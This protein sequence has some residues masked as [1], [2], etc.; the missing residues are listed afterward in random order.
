MIDLQLPR[1]LMT[2]SLWPRGEGVGSIF[3]LA[4]GGPFSAL[5]TRSFAVPEHFWLREA[6]PSLES[7]IRAAFSNRGDVEIVT[8]TPLEKAERTEW[9]KA[10]A[11]R[12][13]V[14]PALR[15]PSLADWSREIFPLS[16]SEAGEVHWLRELR[17]YEL[18]LGSVT[19]SL[20]ALRFWPAFLRTRKV[21]FATT[22]AREWADAQALFSPQDDSRGEGPF[23]LLNPTLQI[24]TDKKEMHAI[25]RIEGAL[26]SRLVSWEQAAVLDEM[27]ETPR[28]PLVQLVSEMESRKFSFGKLENH[29][30]FGAVIKQMIHDGLILLRN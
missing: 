5:R 27:R 17:D 29:V 23:A 2:P 19:P 13:R 15:A 24:V 25:W 26:S 14:D 11:K 21:H 18:Q 8:R 4:Y 9:E 3:H 22:A 6:T 16:F 7:V 12:F 28:L 10:G 20:D 30:P 1:P